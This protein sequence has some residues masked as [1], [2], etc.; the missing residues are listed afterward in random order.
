[1][2][3]FKVKST[4]LDTTTFDYDVLY[5]DHT[6][7]YLL[8][9]IVSGNDITIYDS[10]PVNDKTE[11]IVYT[12]HIDALN[13]T[14]NSHL[15]LLGREKASIVLIDAK[16]GWDSA[17]SM[18][19]ELGSVV[20]SYGIWCPESVVEIDQI[21]SKVKSYG[22]YINYIAMNLNPL[23]FN[24]EIVRYCESKGLSI[25]GLNPMGGLL[26]SGRNIEAFTVPY[27][28]GFSSAYSEIVVLSG[29]NQYKSAESGRY[30]EDNLID[31]ELDKNYILKKT[32]NKPV[33]SIS[34]AIYTSTRLFGDI[35]PYDDPFLLLDPDYSVIEIGKSSKVISSKAI[36]SKKVKLGSV[37]DLDGEP[38][39]IIKEVNDLLSILYYPSD[40]DIRSKFACAKYKVL[41]Y[42]GYEFNTE[43]GWIRNFSSIGSTILLVMVSKAPKTTGMLWWK[44]EEPGDVRNFCLY[45]DGTK[46]VFREIFDEEEKEE[47]VKP[48]EQTS[49]DLPLS[50]EEIA[51]KAEELVNNVKE[52]KEQDKIEKEELI[53]SIRSDIEKVNLE[54]T[55]TL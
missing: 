40:G 46:F 29:R 16:S 48:I 24:Y 45:N 52:Q 37:D 18:F 44:K 5:T 9:S 20:G 26:S 54:S 19:V 13:T 43:S 31:K 6:Y 50:E 23:E 38:K 25:I 2:T 39:G 51:K 4:C 30:I 11:L 3:K 34:K 42:L 53:K 27:L 35:L 21:L 47:D 10:L 36:D 32:I 22:L 12:N 14:L 17:E 28:L 41:D 7:D 8:T 1:M 55:E 33:K 15:K 49:N